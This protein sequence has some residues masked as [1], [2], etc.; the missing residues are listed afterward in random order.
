LDQE[1]V[2]QGT[3]AH[4]GVRRIRAG[5]VSLFEPE[6]CDGNHPAPDQ[7]GPVTPLSSCNIE[8]KRLFLAKKPSVSLG[9]SEIRKENNRGSGRFWAFGVLR[10]G[11]G[12]GKK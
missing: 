8:K 3:R 12:S 9:F 7:I 1:G 5:F 11:L 10:R 4:A 2:T 6:L